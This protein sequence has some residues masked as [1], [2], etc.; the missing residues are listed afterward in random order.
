MTGPVGT[1]AVIDSGVPMIRS[2]SAVGSAANPGGTIT[3][4]V[5]ARSEQGLALAYQWSVTNGWTL[6]GGA[7]TSVA[8]IIA[9]N[10][11]T[12]S[13]TAVVLVTDTRSGSAAGTIALSTAGAFIPVMESISIYPQPVLTTANL[14][15]SASDANNDPLTYSWTIGGIIGIAEGGSAAW[16]SPGIPGRYTVGLAVSDGTA[17]VLGGSS[18]VVGSASPWPK[19]RRDIQG[20]GVSSIDTSAVTSALTWSYATGNDDVLSS[21]AIGADGTVY[22]GSRN[23]ILY[24]IK[25]DGTGS[26][27]S[28]TT[29]GAIVS[30]PAIGADGTVYVGS[31][32]NNLYAINSDG[33]LKWNYATGNDVTSSPAI[34]ADGTVYVGSYDHYL[35][36]INPNG[37]L[38]W[39]YTSGNS[40]ASSPAIGADGTVYVGSHD[41][42]LYAINPSGTLKW[43]YTTGGWVYSSP[44]IGADGTVYVGSLDRNLYAINPDGTLKWSY[45]TGDWVD[46]SPALGADG[47]VYV[48]S[49]DNYL[50]AINPNGTLKWSYATGDD[51]T[52]SP[53]IGADG[54]VYVGSYD[55]RLYAINP[56]GTLKWSYSTGDYVSSSPAIGADGTVYVGSCSNRLYAIK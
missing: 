53:A 13:G 55:N 4:T 54:T 11:Y 39:N 20:T 7:T 3:V 6:S 14:A 9:P 36:A 49:Y 34:G 8:S 25:S 17:T 27:W 52:S 1:N 47:T 40:V 26:K 45:T 12:A 33:T 21:P 29:G 24:A 18:L 44:A 23:G 35:Y 37:T 16:S 10:S 22:V 48:G 51:V 28:Y 31:Y 19:F 46:S 41:H 43:S 30:S 38:K 50:Y 32:D 2:I 42:K 56:N 15:A 5:D